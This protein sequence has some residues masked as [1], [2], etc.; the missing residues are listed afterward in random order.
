MGRQTCAISSGWGGCEC[1]G[2]DNGMV[3]ANSGP[4]SNKK[5]VTFDWQETVPGSGSCK[6][7]H[8][9]GVFDGF[10]NSPVMVA[11]PVGIPLV[12]TVEF[13]LF[14]IGNGEFFE[15]RDGKMD[16]FALGFVPYNCDI[17]G[18]IDCGGAQP[19]IEAFLKNGNYFVVA[20]PYIFDGKIVGLYDKANATIG[21]PETGQWAVTEP[22][23]YPD[24]TRADG[25]FDATKATFAPLPSLSATNDTDAGF[26]LMEIFVMGGA[27]NWNAAWTGPATGGTGSTP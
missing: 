14:Q 22:T 10:Y 11:S 3:V 19:T 1:A 15:I 2:A 23:N 24:I 7:G 21:M 27:G 25:S 20:F 12:G 8:Y 5:S 13:D 6:A 4:A 17:K 16:G 9:A 18:T 26:P